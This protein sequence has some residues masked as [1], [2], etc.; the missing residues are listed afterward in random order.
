MFLNSLCLFKWC[1]QLLYC[2]CYVW[3]HA[4][5]ASGIMCYAGVERNEN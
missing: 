2:R 5:A 1:E 4:I 3:F